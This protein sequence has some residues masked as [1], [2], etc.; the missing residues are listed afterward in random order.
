MNLP[1]VL[2]T[3][4]WLFSEATEWHV[5]KNGRGVPSAPREQLKTGRVCNEIN[6]RYQYLMGEGL[7]E[8]PEKQVTIDQR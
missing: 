1:L 7:K 2:C 4:R 3:V 8:K 5:R 6:F